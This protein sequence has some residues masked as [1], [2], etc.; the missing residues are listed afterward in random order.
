MP[1]EI[2]LKT[3]GYLNEAKIDSMFSQ[4]N[5]NVVRAHSKNSQWVR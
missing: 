5:G 1:D 3:Y 2:A 4:L